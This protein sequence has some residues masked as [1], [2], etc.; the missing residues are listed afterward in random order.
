MC[1]TVNQ[2]RSEFHLKKLEIL[3]FLKEFDQIY[4]WKIL[5]NDE[6]ICSKLKFYVFFVS[7][8][9][10]LSFF[11]EQFGRVWRGARW[12][13]PNVR[14]LPVPG[15]S[16]RSSDADWTR[17]RSSWER[18]RLS[19]EIRSNGCYPTRINTVWY[20]TRYPLMKTNPHISV[21]IVCRESL[22]NGYNFIHFFF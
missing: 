8:M 2:F 20:P 12:M 16:A 11:S 1:F 13:R 14:P 9:R 17:L 10:D 21:V 6:R 5:K 18:M 4:E 22:A 3:T 15:H 19:T 7:T